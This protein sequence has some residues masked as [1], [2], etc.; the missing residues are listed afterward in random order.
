MTGRHHVEPLKRIGLFAGARLIEPVGGIGEL[1]AELRDKFRAHFIAAATYGRAK[2]SEKVG[3]PG[4]KVHVELADCFLHDAREGAAPTGVD[5]RNGA[6]L[7]ID[8]KDGNAVSGLNTE[9]QARSCGNG[10]VARPHRRTRGGSGG[11]GLDEAN[12]IGM[13]LLEWDERELLR[14]EG[15]LETAAV[16]QDVFAGIPIGKAE[17]EDGFAIELADAS[18]AR[19]E[20]VNEPGEFLKSIELKNPQ[21]AGRDKRPR[22]SDGGRRS[23]R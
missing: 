12:H 10:S 7:W 1:R 18:R 17:V 23:N 3:R 11:R 6:A 8:K 21:P 22:R 14:A 13:N 9:E 15:G 4:A 19:A 2:S 16:F 20:A 5:G